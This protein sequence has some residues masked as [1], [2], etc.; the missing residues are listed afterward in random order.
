MIKFLKTK[1][2]CLF[3]CT[4]IPQTIIYAQTGINTKKPIQTF[5]VD[6][7]NDNSST[8]TPSASQQKNDFVVTANGDVGIGTIYPV[9]KLEVNGDVR[10]TDVPAL[11][12]MPKKILVLDADGNLFYTDVAN[13][14][15]PLDT[16]IYSII[17]KT[18]RQFLPQRNVFYNLEFDGPVEGV[19]ADQLVVSADKK[20]LFLPPNKTLK[21][22]GSIGIIGAA[23][24]PTK[25]NPAYIISQFELQNFNNDGSHQLVT[26]IGYT[27][28]STENYDDGGV[29]MPIIIVRTGSKGANVILNVKY[30]GIDSPT[31]GYYIG[32][33]ANDDT[34]ASYIL[35][36]EI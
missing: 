30:N 19:N 11:P 15:P 17:N 23:I 12:T 35:I 9:T 21:L 16:R 36:E 32:G 20:K 34:L 7:K 3:V 10:I 18:S 5:H 33:A 24:N 13:V 22:T 14:A 26:T 4:M 2:L 8:A 6:G 28:S 1:C 27:E 31:N 29:S 25:T